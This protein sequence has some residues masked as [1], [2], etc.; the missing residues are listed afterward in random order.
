MSDF[1]S[2]EFLENVKRMQSMINSFQTPILQNIKTSYESAIEAIL[3]SLEPLQQFQEMKNSISSEV[4]ELIQSQQIITSEMIKQMRTV[5]EHMP[6]VRL[7]AEAIRNSIPY[8]QLAAIDFS[9]LRDL[10]LDNEVDDETE[11]TDEMK[12][13][14]QQEIQIQ[15]QNLSENESPTA[16][17]YQAFFEKLAKSIPSKILINILLFIMITPFITPVTEDMQESITAVWEDNLQVDLTGEYTAAIRQ[18]T[19][20]RDGRS[21]KA[22]VVLSQLLK[23]GQP[24]IVKSRKGSW[25]RVILLVDGE[26][27]TGWV[28]KSRIVK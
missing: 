12:V 26:T 14:I 1:P 22:P 28:E 27:Y 9:Y 21:R 10:S 4:A 24:I 7:T 8:E 2:K 23:T 5:L 6:A 11:L 3:A 19:Y 25:V 17:T 16:D 20:L 13:Q 18:D 15:F